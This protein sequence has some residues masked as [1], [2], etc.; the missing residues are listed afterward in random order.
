VCPRLFYLEADN[1]MDDDGQP[2]EDAAV[3]EE[4]LVDE[5]AHAHTLVVSMHALAGIRTYHTML[6]PVMIKGECLLGLLDTGSTH[7]FL[8]GAAMC[9]LG[10]A[11]QGGDQLRVN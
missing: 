6:L 8:Q 3:P 5:A 2:A 11:P 4:Q 7:T 10:L 1:F 9:H